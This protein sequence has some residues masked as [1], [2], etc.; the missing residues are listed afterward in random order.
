MGWG[1]YF[2]TLPTC[3]TASLAG[4]PCQ[5]QARLFFHPLLIISKLGKLYQNELETRKA[6]ELIQIIIL[7][8][9]THHNYN[10]NQVHNTHHQNQCIHASAHQIQ[11]VFLQGPQRYRDVE[12]I[13]DKERGSQR[14]VCHITV[15]SIHVLS[16]YCTEKPPATH[17]LPCYN[18]T[19]FWDKCGQ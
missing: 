16:H 18:N 4:H 1:K 5:H 14:V 19:W 6:C 2:S 12:E 17:C 15:L 7:I 13:C 9:Y 10:I 3:P 11:V 8:N